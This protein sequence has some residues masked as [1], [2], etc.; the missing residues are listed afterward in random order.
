MRTSRPLWAISG[1]VV[2]GLA[3]GLMAVRGAASPTPSSAP[4]SRTSSRVIAFDAGAA[5]ITFQATFQA[6]GD[7]TTVAASA[8]PDLAARAVS[9]VWAGDRWWDRFGFAAEND[10]LVLVLP[11]ENLT[12][13][14]VVLDAAVPL[15]W[16]HLYQITATAVTTGAASGWMEVR[17]ALVDVGPMLEQ[18][19]VPVAIANGVLGDVPAFGA[20]GPAPEYAGFSDVWAPAWGYPAS[21]SAQ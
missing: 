14:S 3:I 2:I 8:A 18:P 15:R 20:L 11:D 13:G 4:V 5:Q 7:S 21:T 19:A 17:W 10:R 1:A 6:L 9:I 12:V 16:N